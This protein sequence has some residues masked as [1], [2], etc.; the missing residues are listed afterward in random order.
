M[1]LFVPKLD[2]DTSCFWNSEKVYGNE[3]MS[4]FSFKLSAQYVS[5]T[6]KIPLQSF[7]LGYAPNT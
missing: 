6:F 5:Q 7:S 2:H 1:M 3:K 4:D